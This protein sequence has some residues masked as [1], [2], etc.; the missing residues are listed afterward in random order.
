MARVRLQSCAV[1]FERWVAFS[2][3]RSGPLVEYLKSI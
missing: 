1:E 3:K 2:L